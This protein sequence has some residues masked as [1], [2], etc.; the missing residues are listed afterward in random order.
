V[1]RLASRPSGA[2]RLSSNTAFRW[3][4]RQYEGPCLSDKMALETKNLPE[5]T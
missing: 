1:E 5:G 3:A 4:M 2:K